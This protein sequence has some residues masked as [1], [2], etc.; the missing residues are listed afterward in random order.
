MRM[1]P[2]IEFD[3]PIKLQSDWLRGNFAEAQTQRLSDGTYLTSIPDLYEI[4]NPVSSLRNIFHG[5]VMRRHL[6]RLSQPAGLGFTETE[7]L[8]SLFHRLAPPLFF[9]NSLCQPVHKPGQDLKLL[10]IGKTYEIVHRGDRHHDHSS[11][12]LFDFNVLE[13][14]IRSFRVERLD[15]DDAHIHLRHF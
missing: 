7:S 14:D 12:D 3:I 8:S 6:G 4:T 15:F 1:I 9:G 10:E 13:L 2:E 5:A 11:P